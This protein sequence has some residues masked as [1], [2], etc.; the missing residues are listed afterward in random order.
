MHRPGLRGKARW[1]SYFR[2][3][4]NRRPDD[5]PRN[6]AQLLALSADALLGGVSVDSSQNVYVSCF[7]VSQVFRVQ[8]G[9]NREQVLD[10]CALGSRYWFFAGGL[11]D[12]KA[13]I[14]VTDTKTAAVRT[15][16][17]PQGTPFQP[18]QDTSA[19]ETGSSSNLIAVPIAIDATLSAKRCA[20]KRSPRM[21]R[22]R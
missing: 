9:G 4:A 1:H 14:T 10:A 22:P 15:Y 19:F 18:L 2:L 21:L 12:V 17:N 11:T 6:T 5:V 16:T 20:R 13:V 8:P 3:L 7:D